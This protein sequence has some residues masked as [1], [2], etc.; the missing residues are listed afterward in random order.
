MAIY[1]G[2]KLDNPI[3][4]SALARAGWDNDKP[5][6]LLFCNPNIPTLIRNPPLFIGNFNHFYSPA[7]IIA[8]FWASPSL[9]M[10]LN[11]KSKKWELKASM[12]SK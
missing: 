11:P 9:F 8:L 6:F 2:C 3:Q 10:Y 12:M 4:N 1:V 7:L 5:R